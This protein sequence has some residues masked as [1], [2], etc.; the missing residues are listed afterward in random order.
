MPLTLTIPDRADLIDGRTIKAYEQPAI[1][2]DTAARWWREA[3]VYQI[4]PRSFADGNGDGVGDLLGARA[5]LPYLA[6]LGI[7]AVWLSPFYPSP[8]RDFGYDITDYCDVDPLFGTLDDFD[9]FLADAHAHG[10]RVIADFVPNHTSDMHPWFLASRASRDGP[11]ADW[12]IWAD[13]APEGGP[14]NNWR[15]VTGGPAWSW[16]E[17]RGQYALHSFLPFQ[18]DLNLAHPPVRDALHAAMRFWLDRGVDGLRVDMVDFLA[19]DARLRD[20]PD[21]EYSFASAIHHLN[22]PE[23]DGV[24]R[25]LMD[26]AT[27]YG[28]RVIVGEINPG[29][30]IAQSVRYYGTAD[31]PLMHLPFNFGLMGQPFEAKALGAFIRAYEAALPAYAW[32]NATLGNHDVSRLASRVG[33]AN[34][35]VAAMLLLT[36]RGTPFLYGGDELGLTDVAIPPDR[37]QDPWEARVSG[38]GR[39]PNR[40]PMPWQADRPHAGF[41]D[42]EPWLPVGDANRRRAVDRQQDD[43]TSLLSLYRDLLALRR[44]N[45]A[46]RGGDLS[47]LDPG[48]GVIAYRRAAPV[49]V[50]DG[51]VAP[52]TP[53]G[54]A[55][56]VVLNPGTDPRAVPIPDGYEE[57]VLATDGDVCAVAGQLVLPP[58]T[59]AI[60]RR[61]S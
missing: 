6:H 54:D 44:A 27:P 45:P 10:I 32:P 52:P 11:Q 37:A 46:L 30:S 25:G 23:I 35:R 1:E 13:A 9:G 58:H 49:P 29:L 50:A 55:V 7:D 18:P 14:P 39:D 24:L 12:Y 28:D 8:M 16:H 34:A 59:G 43:P 33:E 20:E 4:Y 38:R 61:A 57:I 19:K 42:A 48:E 51:M 2:A 60:L 21:P 56:L 22:R 26:V 53:G 17:G 3:V 5:R 47:M 31:A 15:S 36:L 41:S 40:T